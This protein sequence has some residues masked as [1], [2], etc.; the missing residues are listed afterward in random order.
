MGSTTSPLCE[1]ED[2]EYVG[3]G[4]FIGLAVTKS[5]E[6]VE[7][8][9]PENSI[10]LPVTKPVEGTPL[11]SPPCAKRLV[12]KV[13]FVRDVPSKVGAPKVLAAMP[14][15]RSCAA[16]IFNLYNRANSSIC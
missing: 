7:Y 3:A 14:R 10:G 13:F 4:N 2:A 8:G 12:A 9:E 15:E 11:T 1:P 6:L 5:I 16:V